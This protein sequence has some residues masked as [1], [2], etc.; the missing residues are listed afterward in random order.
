MEK[1]WDSGH[2]TG[3]WLK[4]LPEQFQQVQMTKLD[5]RLVYMQMRLS[6]GMQMGNSLVNQSCWLGPRN[7]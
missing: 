5:E 1:A 7:N 2:V 6:N 4:E 3:S